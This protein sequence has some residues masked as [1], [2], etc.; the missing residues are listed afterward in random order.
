M[1]LSH[2]ERPTVARW[3]STVRAASG[4]AAIAVLA[5]G[6][7]CWLSGGLGIGTATIGLLL[8]GV[9]VGAILGLLASTPIL[10]WLGS[11]GPSPARCC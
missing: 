10:H 8:A 11:R 7:G 2:R 5:G 3:R 1:R 6:R 4:W 9:T